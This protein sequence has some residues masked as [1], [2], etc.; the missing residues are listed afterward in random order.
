MH[1]Y[2]CVFLISD[3]HGTE[4]SVGRADFF[5]GSGILDN[6]CHS[7]GGAVQSRSFVVLPGC[8]L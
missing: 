8:Y 2:K 7:D 4:S 3:L 1:G 5:L 6:S